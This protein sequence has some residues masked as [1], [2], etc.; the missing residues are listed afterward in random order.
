MLKDPSIFN[1]SGLLKAIAFNKKVIILITAR[2]NIISLEFYN[3]V[4]V[5]EEFTLFLFP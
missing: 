1:I 4:N 5:Y 2:Y 3:L